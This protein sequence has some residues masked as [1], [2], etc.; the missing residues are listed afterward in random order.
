MSQIYITAFDKDR[1]TNL[2][3]KKLRLDDYDQALLAELKQ[4]NVVEPQAI[5]NDVIT[6]NSQCRLKEENGETWDCTLVFPEDADYEQDKISILSPV[7]CS[8]IGNKIGSTVSF[9]SPKGEKKV[10][11]EDILY[12]PERSGD[13]DI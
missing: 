8:L 3:D 1:L 9:P 12:Q 11:V 13:M 10:T 7:G 2:L 4:A 5:P 6:M